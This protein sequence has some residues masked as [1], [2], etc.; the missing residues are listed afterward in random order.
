[1]EQ[2]LERL[3]IESVMGLQNGLVLALVAAGFTL[4]LGVMNIVNFAHGEFYMA[5]A[6]AGWLAL[7]FG[8]DIV[9]F[10]G[11]VVIAGVVV[12]AFGLP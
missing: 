3:V 2:F 8:S 7:K 5:G 9:G 6:F 10:W 4:I 1:M 12:A 11:A